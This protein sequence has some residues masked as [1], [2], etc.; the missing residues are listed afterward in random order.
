M[1][2]L[3]LISRALCSSLCVCGHDI[4]CSTPCHKPSFLLPASPCHKPSFASPLFLVRGLV[5]SGASF[6]LLTCPLSR[7]PVGL[8]L[9]IC[10]FRSTHITSKSLQDGIKDSDNLTAK[11]SKGQDSTTPVSMGL[12]VYGSGTL[13]TLTTANLGEGKLQLPPLPRSF[14]S[15]HEQGQAPCRFL[16]WVGYHRVPQLHFHG[17]HAARLD[18]PLPLFGRCARSSSRSTAIETGFMLFVSKRGR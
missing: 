1:L 9:F 14:P 2:Y 4:P 13:V 6:V 12:S 11:P 15:F 8:P 7:P 17:R 10:Q 16:G 5:G 18:C 3:Y